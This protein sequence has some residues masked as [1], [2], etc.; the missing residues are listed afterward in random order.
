MALSLWSRFSPFANAFLR[1]QFPEPPEPRCGATPASSQPPA[2][3]SAI[4]MSC[5]QPIQCNVFVS[6]SVYSS[7]TPN[8]IIYAWRQHVRSPDRIHPSHA[9]HKTMRPDAA[10]L[11]TRNC[12][13]QIQLNFLNLA[14]HSLFISVLPPL[15]DLR[16]PNKT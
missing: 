2:A 5:G 12:S 8:L 3:A 7:V 15:P 16:K 6:Q 4:L 11:P 14:K 9:F 10:G 13:G 1:L